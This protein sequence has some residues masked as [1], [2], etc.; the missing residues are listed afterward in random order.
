MFMFC[1]EMTECQ[2]HLLVK[3]LLKQT[4]NSGKWKC[5]HLPFKMTFLKNVCSWNLLINYYMPQI[6]YPPRDCTQSISFF[7]ICLHSSG[8]IDKATINIHLPTDFTYSDF[9]NF[10]CTPSGKN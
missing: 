3:L 9:S 2:K 8:A 1:F 7:P 5:I 6:R 4:I 10:L